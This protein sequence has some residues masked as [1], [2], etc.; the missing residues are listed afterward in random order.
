MAK[1]CFLCFK[2]KEMIRRCVAQPHAYTISL[3]KSFT[4][5]QGRVNTVVL[6]LRFDINF[7]YYSIVIPVATPPAP[8]PPP[9]PAAP[10]DDPRPHPPVPKIKLN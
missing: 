5:L 2:S 4:V 8:P 1:V 9:A 3:F 7:L 6:I 10:A